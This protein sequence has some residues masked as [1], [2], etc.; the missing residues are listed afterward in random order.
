MANISLD[1]I[2]P[3]DINKDL[4]DKLI[5][6]TNN[7]YD[8]YGEDIFKHKFNI[9]IYDVLCAHYIVID[10]FLENS[11][12]GSGIG[13]IGCKDY[14]LLASAIDRITVGYLNEDKWKKPEEKAATLFYGII[15]NHAFHDANKRTAF[16]TLLFFIERF[17]KRYTGNPSEL[18]D[19]TVDIANND[20]YKYRK[21]KKIRTKYDREVYFL[22]KWIR[23]RVRKEN[24]KLYIITF[25]KL[26]KKLKE[27]GYELKNPS[28]NYIYVVRNDGY[29]KC[30]KKIISKII[31]KTEEENK[32]VG[33]IGFPG[34]SKQVSKSDLSTVLRVTKIDEDHGFDKDAFFKDEE[35]FYYILTNYEEQL[36]RLRDR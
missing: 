16:L 11:I 26:N 14:K 35:P 10:F 19:L 5:Y 6:D 28:G 3:P 2:N 23:K 7:L 21:Y 4:L 9:S 25:K 15:K 33:K 27:Y 12:E 20:L 32:T 18:E 1:Q 29:Y 36:T 24:K 17:G 8:L 22:S 13:G 30:L 31:P 34:W